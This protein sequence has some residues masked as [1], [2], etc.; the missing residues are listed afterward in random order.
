M[1]IVST[2]DGAENYPFI[3]CNVKEIINCNFLVD[4]KTGFVMNGLVT[5]DSFPK[6]NDLL[7]MTQV[8]VCLNIHDRS[9]HFDRHI[10]PAC[11]MYACYPCLT[12]HAS[13]HRILP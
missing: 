11:P 4:H 8:C 9:L 7:T 3:H 6:G 5:E 13:S 12:P 2:H 1:A 10:C